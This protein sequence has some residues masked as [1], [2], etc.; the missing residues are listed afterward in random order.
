M[1]EVYMSEVLTEQERED[2]RAMMQQAINEGM[3]GPAEVVRAL[4]I[5][6]LRLLS[7]R[8]ALSAQ[9]L[10]L[11][12]EMKA[13]KAF[14]DLAI[15][16]RAKAWSQVKDLRDERDRTTAT[17]QELQAEVKRWEQIADAAQ[18]W[19]DHD[20]DVALARVKELEQE[21]EKLRDRKECSD[22]PDFN[23]ASAR[24]DEAH[25]MQDNAARDLELVREELRYVYADF[26]A[27]FERLAKTEAQISE[28]Y[29][30]QPRAVTE[31]KRETLLQVERERDEA[32]ALLRETREVSG[33]CLTMGIS[34]SNRV[35]ALLGVSKK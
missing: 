9:S 26:R 18:Q 30:R 23:P 35:D 12:A 28:L 4:A 8:N 7:E 2:F 10:S 21:V 24:S 6:T 17:I 27:T 33:V 20:R 29:K 1:K 31:I 34:W 32:Q 19:G 22:D 11:H 14:H 15:Q 13:H 25:D 16:E 3:M 5:D